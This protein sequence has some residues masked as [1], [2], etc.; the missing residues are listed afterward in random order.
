MAQKKILSHYDRWL[1]AANAAGSAENPL[2]VPYDI[3]LKE[4]GQVAGFMLKYWEQAAGLPG[5]QRVK[6]RLP[7]STGDDIISSSTRRRRPRPGCSSSSIR[8]W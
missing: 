8:W 5:L 3:T 4:A 1:E 2:K 7:Q 6:A